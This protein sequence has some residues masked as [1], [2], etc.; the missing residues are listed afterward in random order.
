M[1]Q[2]SSWDSLAICRPSSRS[3][4]K[5]SSKLDHPC[6]EAPG[7]WRRRPPR[8]R[9]RSRSMASLDLILQG[10]LAFHPAEQALDSHE[11]RACMVTPRSPRPGMQ[12]GG[13]PP[14][15]P[16]VRSC[17]TRGRLGESLAEGH[18]RR[19]PPRLRAGR[20]A[21]QGRVPRSTVL[22]SE[23]GIRRRSAGPG[24][25][26]PPADRQAALQGSLPAQAQEQPRGGRPRRQTPGALACDLAD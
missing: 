23:G 25:W 22:G 11:G 26:S 1:S 14:Q 13:L 18:W 6:R 5:C 10:V 3:L 17:S 8:A 20:C 4:R 16:R 24:R 2:P 19:E 12:P 9:A 21:V 15:G 7:A